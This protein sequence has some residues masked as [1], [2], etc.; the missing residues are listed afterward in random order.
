MENYFK[1]KT[2][3]FYSNQTIYEFIG[4]K[5]YKKYLPTTGDIARKYR[6][7]VQIKLGKSDRINELYRYEK[8]TR[9]YEL[10]H[11]IGTIVFIALIFIVDK[12]LNLFDVFFLTT[13]NTYVNIYPIFLQRYNRMRIIKILLNNDQKSPHDK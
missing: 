13:L 2:F 1:P 12:K 7:I 3:E 5:L 6:N 4:I 10:R 11:I 9:N 8:R